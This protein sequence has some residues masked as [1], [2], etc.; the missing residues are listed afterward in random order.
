MLGSGNEGKSRS[1]TEFFKGG[2]TFQLLDLTAAAG[3]ALQD[4]HV[5]TS[6][7]MLRVGAIG[8]PASPFPPAFALVR[9][10]QGAHRSHRSSL[11]SVE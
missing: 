11:P 2:R 3:L 8:A 7:T 9:F 6:P 5:Q 1:P 10:A 4:S